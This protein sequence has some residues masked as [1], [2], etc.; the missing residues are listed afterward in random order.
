MEYGGRC[1]KHFVVA[2]GREFGS[3]GKQIGQ[4]L[5]QN[6]NVKCYDD[7][8][9]S[10]VEKKLQLNKHI[11]TN[12]DEKIKVNVPSYMDMGINSNAEMVFEAQREIILEAAEKESCIFIGRCA[13]YILKDRDDLVSIFVYAP[14][15]VRFSKLKK[16]YPGVTDNGIKKMIEEVE[17]KRHNYHKYF[18]KQNRASRDYRQ[19]MIDSSLLGI[20]G[21]A[22]L[23]QK[24]IE[25]KFRE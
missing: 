14:Y 25:D 9:V 6:L 3:G 8:L 17:Y 12:V 2:I 16:E 1:M 11:V 18:T 19:L 5:A 4:I 15:G 22:V 20:E 10:L 7:E 23:I 24:L 13:D 21:T